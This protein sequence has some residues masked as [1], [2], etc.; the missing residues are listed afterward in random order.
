MRTTLNAD[1]ASPWKSFPLRGERYGYVKQRRWFEFV[2]NN[3]YIKMENYL[4]V[5]IPFL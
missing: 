2:I 5:Q 4:S 3:N 1:Y